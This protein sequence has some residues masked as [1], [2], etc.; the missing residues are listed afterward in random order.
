MTYIGPTAAQ[1]PSAHSSQ[2]QLVAPDSPTWHTSPPHTHVPGPHFQ[3]YRWEHV[4]QRLL[5][6]YTQSDHMLLHSHPE[7]G[8]H[9]RAPGDKRLTLKL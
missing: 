6:T 7:H 1:S 9:P 4:Y 3:H 8:F 5:D 2:L